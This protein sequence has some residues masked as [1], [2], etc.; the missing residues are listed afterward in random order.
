MGVCPPGLQREHRLADGRSVVVRPIR[1]ADEAGEREFFERLSRETKRLRFL[2]FA[3]A[4]N[5]NLLHFF[6]H[7]D[8]DRHMAFVCEHDGR[9]VGE[10]RYQANPDNRSCEFGIVIGDDWHHSGIAALLMA[11][12]VDAARARGFQ[13]MEGLVLGTNAAM[14]GFVEELGFRREPMPSEP[15]MVRVV[16]TL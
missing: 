13:T 3:E 4:L 7:I 11:A 15:A 5:E 16:K 1:A 2:K 8:Y 14:L 12:L 9:I 10:A 6:T